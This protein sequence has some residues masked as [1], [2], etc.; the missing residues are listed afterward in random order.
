MLNVVDEFT[1]ESLAIRVARKLKHWL[2]KAARRTAD[3][4][5][6]AIGPI[7]DSVTSAE[8]ANYFANAGYAQPK[9]IPL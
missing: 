8:C 1:H 3:A 7:L 2:R 4:V 5:C 6:D 9:F